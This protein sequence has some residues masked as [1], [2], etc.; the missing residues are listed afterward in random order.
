[1]GAILGRCRIG[2]QIA[3]LGLLGVVGMLLVAGINQWGSAQ[4]ARSDAAVAAARDARDRD[5]QLQVLILQARRH[6][7]DFQLRRDG[8]LVARHA[9]AMAGFGRGLD[10]L[11]AGVGDAPAVQ[12]QIAQVRAGVGRYAAAFGVLV[13]AAE[14]VGLNEDQG[15]MGA[16]RHDVHDVETVLQGIDAPRVL[17]GMLQMRRN[18]KDF[19][20]R[21]DPKYGAAVKDGLPGLIAALDMAAPSAELRARIVTDMTAYQERFAALMAATLDEKAA[22]RGLSAIYAEIEPELVALDETFAAR[23]R[24]AE[25]QSEA[26]AVAM[27][28]QVFG[29]LAVVALVVAGLGWLVG[30]NIARPI[31]AVT[32][33]MEALTAG[34]L[35]TAVPADDRRDEIGTMVRAVRTFRDGMI[36]AARLREAQVAQ[37]ERAAQETRAALMGMA[38]EIERSAEH[39]VG[40]IGARTAT[41]IGI[42]EE[43]GSLANRS[44]GSAREAAEAAAQA[45]ANAQTVASAAE[46]LSASINEISGQV[47]R[48]AATVGHAVQA[49]NETRGTIEDLNERVRRIGAVADLIGD[50][51]SKTNLLALNA[52][53][54]AARAGDAGK[55]FAVVASEVKQLASQTRRSTEEIAAQIGAVRTATLAAVGA[56]GRIEATIAEIDTISGSIAAAVE[57]QGAATAEIA[58]NVAE[59]AAAVNRMS[60]LN[61]E[62]S[63]EAARAGRCADEV[64]ENV[65]GLD[66]SVAELKRSMIRAT[67]TSTAE[68]D[69]RQGP[70]HAAD[71]ACRVEIGGRGVVAARVADISI[72]GAKIVGLAGVDAGAHGRLRLD[73][74]GTAPAFTVVEAD[75]E[76]VHVAFAAE[77]KGL[78]A[79]LERLPVAA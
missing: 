49:G 50:I 52:T 12:A 37:R 1:M 36:E 15:L 22:G 66:G 29:A 16:M 77:E 14:K 76:A 20:A 2:C 9:E 45:L 59:T 78:A 69:R 71:L 41:M 31:V 44:G 30:R 55:G 39:S 17:I 75:A 13:Q 8:E 74:L 18:E 24:S 42:A 21:L 62:A 28:R 3:V 5:G 48:S 65:R 73:G 6:E 63:T 34:D 11:A 43:M 67:R 79:L 70:R 40:E 56:V 72:R 25:A 32:R 46:E 23:A 60:G 35:A 58:R 38:E 51:A 57:Q 64:L 27:H 53:I 4:V 54:E 19:L 33:A 7:K 68:V 26:T 47:S 10:A 61:A